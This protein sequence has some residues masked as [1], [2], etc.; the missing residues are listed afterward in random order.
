MVVFCLLFVI[1]CLLL[2]F[3]GCWLPLVGGGWPSL[4]VGNWLLGVG[5][6]KSVQSSVKVGTIIAEMLL[7]LSF[8]GWVFV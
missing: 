7:T 1:C 2:A 5:C 6:L 3:G 8:F 4:V